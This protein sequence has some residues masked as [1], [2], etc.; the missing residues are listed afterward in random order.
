L[1]DPVGRLMVTTTAFYFTFECRDIGYETVEMRK[2]VGT[3]DDGYRRCLRMP[4]YR[5]VAEDQNLGQSCF[6]A[7]ITAFPF[8]R[9]SRFNGRTSDKAATRVWT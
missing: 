2:E 1:P 8:P 5:H 7:P 6:I 9:C 4:P 3:P